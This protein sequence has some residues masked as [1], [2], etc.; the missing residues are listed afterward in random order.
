MGIKRQ[1]VVH[2][3]QHPEKDVV[4]ARQL[5]ENF[6]FLDQELQTR[7]IGAVEDLI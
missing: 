4:L 5:I 3:L 6:G 7:I 1:K 2:S